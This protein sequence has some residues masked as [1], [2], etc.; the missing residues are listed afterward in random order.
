MRLTISGLLLA[1]CP[2]QAA[3]AAT[4]PFTISQAL[5]APF[6]SELKASPNGAKMAWIENE[7]GRRNIWF[8]A[9]PDWKAEKATAFNEDDGQEIADLAWA[10]DGSFLLF[11]RGGDF[12]NAGE[13][14]NPAIVLKRPDQSIWQFKFDG[15]APAKLTEG[16]S[17]RVSSDNRIVFLRK[18]QIFELADAK[19]VE[20]A[21]QKGEQEAP[22]WSPDGRRFAFVSQRGDHSFIGVYDYGTKQLRYLDASTDRDEDPVWSP[23]GKAVAFIRIRSAGRAAFFRHSVAASRGRFG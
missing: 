11:S 4:G 5:S 12:E 2:L 1:L 17:P 20:L 9:A 6:A 21:E 15:S 22:C 16:R 10:H 18:N 3:H 13:N 8:A 14:P 19:A 23:D 7:Q